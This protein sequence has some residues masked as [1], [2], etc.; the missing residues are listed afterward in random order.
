MQTVRDESGHQYIL[1]KQSQESSLVRDPETGEET[2][3]SNAELTHVDGASPLE[4]AATAVP[5]QLRV[6]VTATHDTQALGLLIELDTRGPLS[7]HELLSA[8]ELCER[9]LHGLLGELRAAGLVT[10]TEVAGRRGYRLTESAKDAV[11]KLIETD[12]TGDS[13]SYRE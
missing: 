12:D 11:S 5:E 4:T 13:R 3:L 9:D 10:E 8:Y 2:H 1:V 7:V 6:V